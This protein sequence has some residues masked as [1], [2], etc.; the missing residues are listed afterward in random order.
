[1]KILINYLFN[2]SIIGCLIGG[3]AFLIIY[4]F[5]TLNVNNDTWILYGYVKCK[6]YAS[7][8]NN[9]KER[10]QSRKDHYLQFKKKNMK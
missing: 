5:E 2:R 10:N 8:K 4:G 1:M 6:F 9:E 3:C 7:F